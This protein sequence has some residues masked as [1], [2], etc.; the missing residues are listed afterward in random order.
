MATYL[1]DLAIPKLKE[2]LAQPGLRDSAKAP[3]LTLLGEAQVRAGLYPQALITLD[4]PLLREFS[5]AHLWR[6]YA[7]SKLGRLRDALGELKRI[8]RRSMRAQADLEM[9]SI[10][11]VIG[12]SANAR[13]KLE[14]LLESKQGDLAKQAILQ[15]SSLSLLENKLNETAK[16]LSQFTPSNPQ[17]E[18]LLSYLTGRL[19]LARGEKEAAVETFTKLIER[20]E[21]D[22]NLP[23]ELFHEATLAL[24]DSLSLQG[25]EEAAVN[26]LL[27]TLGKYPDSPLMTEIFGRLRLMEPE[28]DTLPLLEKLSAWLPTNTSATPNILIPNGSSVGSF[29]NSPTI[30]DAIPRALYSLEFTARTYLESKDPAMREQGARNLAYLRVVADPESPLVSRSLFALAQE[31]MMEKDYQKARDLFDLIDQGPAPQLL[32]AYA[33]ALSGKASFALKEPE[34]ASQAFQEASEISARLKENELKSLSDLNSGITLLDTSHA[35]ELDALSEK[36]KDPVTKSYLILE[37]GLY[38]SSINQASGR[39]LLTSFLTNFPDNPRRAEAALALAENAIFAE[40]K[41]LELARAHISDAKFNAETSPK[42][43]ARRI[44]VLLTLGEG[45][46]LVTDFLTKSPDHPLGARLLFRQG[47][48]YRDINEIGKAYLAFEQFIKQHPKHEFIDAARY[49]SA[50][51]ALASGTESAEKNAIIRFQELIDNKGALAHESVI[52][53]S[54]LLIDSDRQN[55]A[56]TEIKKHLKDKTLSDND[57]RR[58]LILAADASGQLSNYEQALSYYQDLLAIKS[59]SIATH[60]QACFLQ[61]QVYERL[62]KKTEALESYL[63][64]INRQLNPKEATSL[65]W[66]GFDKCGLEG[67]LSLLER[68]KNWR[69]A[70]SL[71]EKI[72]RSGSPR[73]ED[74]REKAKRIRLEQKIWR[75]R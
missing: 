14:P 44:E 19:Q 46:E 16:L 48:S 56:L 43:A 42:L 20:A 8:D 62:G 24:A 52:A 15:L 72:S 73:A 4:S 47:Q 12:D 34:K 39:D 5:P 11:I 25:G 36:L 58:L 69:A 29:S 75:G 61:G 21:S 71:A 6:S 31:R 32:K 2:L 64:V 51:S 23:S 37:R 13:T 9:A 65:E 55:D 40:P 30:S 49:L 7:L 35:K 33:R 45:Q 53:L 50:L 66:K 54:G 1:P 3:L 27:E 17:E 74:A 70:I 63:S 18:G 41:D 68:E 26:S 60:N 38:L 67:A 59:L 10:M 22:K 28:V 57:R